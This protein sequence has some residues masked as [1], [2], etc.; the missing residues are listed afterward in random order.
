MK[1]IL[2]NFITQ[3]AIIAISIICL[4]CQETMLTKD[5]RNDY[6]LIL[7]IENAKNKVIISKNSLPEKTRI[8]IS[9]NYNGNYISKSELAPKLGYQVDLRKHKGRQVA[10]KTVA[11]FDINGRVLQ[12]N[13][14]YKFKGEERRRGGKKDNKKKKDLEDCFD[15][16]YP[17][18]LMMPDASKIEISDAKG[19]D[20]V[21]AW[22]EANPE[23]Q[24]R[25]TFVY[26]LSIFYRINNFI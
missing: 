2:H 11:Y 18:T 5:F 7:A 21:K 19:W 13:E 16:I 15:F 17:F 14:D 3:I 23:E 20:F 24:A 1:W 8:S 26:P 4:S 25:P 10:D 22:Y 12:A 6:D 9:L